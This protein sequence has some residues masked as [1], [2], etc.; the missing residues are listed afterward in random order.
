MYLK[1]IL[2]FHVLERLNLTACK[3]TDEIETNMQ[4]EVVM[5]YT[6]YYQIWFYITIT[7]LM[8][9]YPSPIILR[10]IAF[11]MKKWSTD[12]THSYAY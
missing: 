1:I 5:K 10:I 3:N 7:L 9:P 4:T 8:S 2:K 6:L 12:R 11:D